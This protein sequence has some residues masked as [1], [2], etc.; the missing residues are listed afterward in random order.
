MLLKIIG[1]VLVV[2]V[3]FIVL[4]AVL[5]GAFWL[6]VIGAVLFAGTAA[7]GAIKSKSGKQIR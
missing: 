2:W 5:K 3:A 7:Y 6:L 4:G 1:G